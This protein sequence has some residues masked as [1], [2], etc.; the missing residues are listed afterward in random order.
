MNKIKSTTAA[1]KW[2][3]IKKGDS[4]A[5]IASLIGKPNSIQKKENDSERVTWIYDCGNEGKR[6]ITF[7]DGF[8]E[9]IDVKY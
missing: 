9:K 2:A 7:K 3:T 8:I 5:A 1:K 4:Q 6:A